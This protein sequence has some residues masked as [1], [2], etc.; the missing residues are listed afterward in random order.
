SGANLGSANQGQQDLSGEAN[1]KIKG[2]FKVISVEEQSIR[3]RFILPHEKRGQ[4]TTLVLTSQ[5]RFHSD[6]NAVTVGTLIVGVGVANQDRSITVEEV[7]IIDELYFTGHI[8]SINGDTI[9]LQSTYGGIETILLTSDTV[10]NT[11]NRENNHQEPAS[12]SDLQV[13]VEINA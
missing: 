1:S 13:G 10:F 8:T 3:A 9:T 4:T 2:A 12:R 11:L 5:T 7:I 6:R